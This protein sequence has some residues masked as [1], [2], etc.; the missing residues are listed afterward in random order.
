MLDALS[1]DTFKGVHHL[2]PFDWAMLI[3]YFSVLAILS[4]FGMHRYAMIRGWMKHRAKFTGEP[5][6]RFATLPRI[7]V[8]LPL[9][10]E[11]YVVGRLI[12]ETSKIDYPRELLQIQVLDD[13]TDDTHPFTQALVEDYRDAGL[14]IEYIHRTNRHGFKA[15]A[16]ERFAH[17]HRRA[18]GDL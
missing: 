1:D 13:S 17:R 14:P 5:P 7:T 15:G 12:E 2:M 8:Q 11:R 9:Y 6:S 4:I 16:R 3:P 10:N 18:G